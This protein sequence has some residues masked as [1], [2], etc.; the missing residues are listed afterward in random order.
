MTPFLAD[1][2]FWVAA[3]ACV[4]AQI[5]IL[6]ATAAARS[7]ARTAR[8]A[9][10]AHRPATRVEEALWAGLPVIG[11]AAVLVLTWRALHP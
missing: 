7:A 9:T 10:P 6:R 4:V 2:I 8:A 5:G 3:V 11:L 1:A